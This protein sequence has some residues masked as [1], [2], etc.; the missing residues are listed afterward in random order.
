[1]KSINISFLK[2]K[3]SNGELSDLEGDM[4]V[5]HTDLEGH[6]YVSYI[7]PNSIHPLGLVF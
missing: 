5:G 1:M 4:D 6:T 7:G 2:F 3:I